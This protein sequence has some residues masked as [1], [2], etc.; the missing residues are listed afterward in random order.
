MDLTV[1]STRIILSKI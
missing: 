1:D